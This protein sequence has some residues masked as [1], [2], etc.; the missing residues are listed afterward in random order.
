[1]FNIMYCLQDVK[2]LLY[3]FFLPIRGLPYTGQ[4]VKA[5][6]TQW[7]ASLRKEHRSTAKMTLG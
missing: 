7:S 2:F 1:M 3:V 4:L 6:W 5:M